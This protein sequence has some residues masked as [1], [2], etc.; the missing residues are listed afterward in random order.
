MRSQTSK[1]IILVVIAGGLAMLPLGIFQEL[2]NLLA[3]VVILSGAVYNRVDSRF[4]GYKFSVN[5][6]GAS[7]TIE[8]S[9]DAVA[10][11]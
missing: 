8:T 6:G 7:A 9:G 5:A 4:R 1:I 3:F 11:E 2:N 10:H